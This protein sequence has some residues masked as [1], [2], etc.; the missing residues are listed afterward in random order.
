MTR[1]HLLVTNDFPPKV[2]GIQ[3]YLWELWRRLPS[4]SFAVLT[5]PYRGAAEFDA[6]QPFRVVR[7]PEPVLSDALLESLGAARAG[8]LGDIVATIQAAQYEVISR[9]LDQLLIVQG[10]PGT[11][12]T[13]VGLHRVSWLLFNRRDRLDP[14]DVLV[15]GPNPAFVRYIA[16]VLPTLGEE[17]VVQLPVQSLEGGGPSFHI[18]C[19]QPLTT[20]ASDGQPGH[21]FCA[22]PPLQMFAAK[23]A[24]AMVPPLSYSAI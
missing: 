11:G 4:D 10:G 16:S 19:R 9:P 18:C 6:E 22:L 2:G 23:P 7:S 15:V 24:C 17:A 5:T 12:K 3:S 14:R 1:K 8:E 13:V 21:S 20:C